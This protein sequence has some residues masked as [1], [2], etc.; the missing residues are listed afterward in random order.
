MTLR[1]VS[2]RPLPCHV[3]DTHSEPWFLESNVTS[4]Y[5]MASDF[6][7]ALSWGKQDLVPA[8]VGRCWLAVSKPVLKEPMVSALESRIA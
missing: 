4:S 5:D 8:T 6:C 1:T 7:L 3:I 2:A